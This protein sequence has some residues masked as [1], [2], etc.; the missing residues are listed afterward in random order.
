MYK[1]KQISNL[2]IDQAFYT[3]VNV[4]LIPGVPYLGTYMD[5]KTYFKDTEK[6]HH[7]HGKTYQ[8]YLLGLFA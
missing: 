6:F 5:V 4:P 3:K 7:T 2:I 8:L 1:N